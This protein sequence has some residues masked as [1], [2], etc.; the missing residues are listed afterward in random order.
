MNVN[1][2]VIRDYCGEEGE[3]P[4]KDVIAGRVL[5][6]SETRAAQL[7]VN[8]LVEETD[9]QP[10]EAHLALVAD[11]QPIA[12]VEPFPSGGVTSVA[13]VNQV[14]R[15]DG[16]RVLTADT[17]GPTTTDT[18]LL[19]TDTAG[20]TSPSDRLE[21][22]VHTTAPLNETELNSGPTT[23]ETTVNDTINTGPADGKLATPPTNKKSR[24]PA[25]K[26]APTAPNKSV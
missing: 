26:A 6:V 3:G 21:D 12:A 2:K 5:A 13:P 23:G 24:E 1:V 7:I 16:T 25:N 8:K 11:G 19:S 15:A 22:A 9:E 10:D 4:N 14:E 18:A 20:A 17:R